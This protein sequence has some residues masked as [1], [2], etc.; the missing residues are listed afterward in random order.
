M[1]ELE[2]TLLCA[3]ALLAAYAL[4]GGTLSRKWGVDPSRQTPA[5]LRGRRGGAAGFVYAALCAA[6]LLWLHVSGFIGLDA[7]LS[8]AALVLCVA[9]LGALG[10]ASLFVSVRHEG[11]DMAQIAGEELFPGAKKA[12][13]ALAAAAFVPAAA[14]LMQMYLE[15]DW[16]MRMPQAG[17]PLFFAAQ[18]AA[19]SAWYP[20]CRIAPGVRS[21]K[22]MQRIAYGG[23][24]LGA[25]LLLA[26]GEGVG[27]LPYLPENLETSVVMLGAS[28]L[29][30]LPVIVCVRLGGGALRALT[31]RETILKR[32]RKKAPA[33]AFD[34]LSAAL[35]ALLVCAGGG[36]VFVPAVLC[37]AALALM[38]AAL[39]VLW[40]RRI[41]R[42]PFQRL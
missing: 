7:A 39:C 5:L 14:A 18:F 9:L 21:E 35:T 3:G 29:T 27:L 16:V 40:L 25:L 10:F 26:A 41:G 20:A 11:A 30:L 32:G 13:Y 24:V 38:C 37:C 8:A 2:M 12:V 42:G 33:W 19:L 34:L 28:A 22:S 36:W 17:Y 23:A 6:E 4:H 1:N 15:A 31:L